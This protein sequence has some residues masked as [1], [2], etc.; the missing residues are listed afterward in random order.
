VSFSADNLFGFDKATLRPEAKLE[1]DKFAAELK[2]TKFDVI[3]VT[4]HTDRIG[5]EAYNM[6]L[7]MERAEAVKGYLV[8]S[9]GIPADK[10]SARGV[11]E[12][13]PVTKLDDCKGTKATKKV[14]ACLQPDRRVEVEVHGTKL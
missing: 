9:A 5:S 4:G 11:G 14:I 7:S 8:E 10:I 6:K 2:G 13:Q 12:A 3:K 1:L